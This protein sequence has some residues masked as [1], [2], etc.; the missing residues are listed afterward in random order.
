MA[1]ATT[2][3][4]AWAGNVSSCT[5]STINTGIRSAVNYNDT[6]LFFGNGKYLNYIDKI[7]NTLV[8]AVNTIPYSS[9]I[10]GLSLHSD[11]LWIYFD[12]GKQFLMDIG[13]KTVVA[14]KDWSE[15]IRY[16]RNVTGYDY[17]FTGYNQ[18]YSGVYIN[19]GVQQGSERLL[20]RVKY[21]PV[22]STQFGNGGYAYA[23]A[24]E[25]QGSP[26]S[27]GNATGVTYIPAKG[28]TLAALYSYG[29]RAPG[30]PNSFSLDYKTASS[31]NSIT[32]IGAVFANSSR[33]YFGWTDG[34]NFGV[35]Y[36]ELAVGT[37]GG[38]LT[39]GKMMMMTDDGGDLS[40]RKSLETV[41]VGA[42]VPTGCTLTLKYIINGGTIQTY[43][44]ISASSLTWFKFA[45]RSDDAPV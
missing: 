3:V 28:D 22:V 37:T 6:Y 27:I 34:T 44:T 17:V 31:G 25:N 10:T 11:T 30:L 20:T 32:K 39:A 43:N 1:N 24:S 4:G 45:R 19:G 8:V 2:G 41:E 15:K 35:D 16:I 18:F 9:N 29:S 38:Y 5:G 33:L 14:T 7:A 12:D 23:F 13:T 42:Y 21:D 36:V 26:D 40:V